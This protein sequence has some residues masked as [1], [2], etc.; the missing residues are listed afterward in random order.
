MLR[1]A[2]IRKIIAHDLVMSAIAWQL[3]WLLRFN[4]EFPYKNWEL[5]LYT[6]PLILLIQAFVY[7]RF[8]LHKGLWRF[9]S[10]PDLWNIF[11]ACV[12]GAL[13]I[14]LVLFMWNR[15]EGIPRSIFILYP[16]LL[17]FLLGGPRLA[18]RM[19]K[20]HSLNLTAV[21]KGKKV[22]I[23]G[24]GSA[25]DMLVRDILR[26]GN[27]QAIG[28]VDD[29]LKLVGS[30][31]HG[32]RVLGTVKDVPKICIDEN[33]GLVIIAIP[34]A[35]NKQMQSILNTCE[36]VQC[37]LRTL[38]SLHDM[39]SGRL[40]VNQLREVSIEDLLGREKIKLDWAALQKGI[41]NKK[42]LVTGGGGSIGSELC[43]QIISL[44][45]SELIVFERSE[46]NLYRV[47]ESLRGTGI[48]CHF[49]LGDLCDREKTHQTIT[50]H[51]PDIIFHAAAYKH[52]PI[53]ERQPREGARNNVL[54]TK[55]I[56]D[57]AHVNNCEKFV[58]I[59]TDKAVNPTNILGATKRVA[60]M[61]TEIMNGRSE[62][63]FITVRFGNVLGSEGSVV[64]L[65][66]EQI[67][68]G[69][70]ISVTHPDITRYFMTI[71][72][73]CQLIMQAC[74][75][76]H[77]GEIYVLDMGEPIKINYLAEQMIRL[78]G[79]IPNEDVDIVYTGLRPG[80][81]MY[82]ELF[83]DSEVREETEHH[84]IYIA[85]HHQLKV[86]E[87]LQKIDVLINKC[88]IIDDESIQQTL[89]ELVPLEN[90][91]ASNVIQI[92]SQNTP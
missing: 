65:F 9:A 47:E 22:L 60:E 68:K 86:T 15:L 50:E 36:K 52:V 12:F 13:S 55:N 41:S 18:Y 5:S 91:T 46:Y 34:S 76:G 74:S 89:K 69:G 57:A 64:P 73:A 6:I 63:R 78:S 42:V 29:Q 45:P 51:K 32:V 31:M 3:A 17:M 90:A 54:G 59:S 58:L 49:V 24:A 28:F 39:V 38:P 21:K 4:L 19:W 62:T 37:E 40:S 25:G 83:Y 81:K 71:P 35:T 26:E 53:L 7:Y 10:L 79:L 84:K 27:Y 16:I 43:K 11:R 77:G 23:V 56:A 67:K 87:V 75:M 70:P 88:E 66:K 8:K 72:E 92:D 30:E 33:I 14:T 2:T 20:D 44:A 82:E 61:Y 80:E 48:N 1:F 85:K